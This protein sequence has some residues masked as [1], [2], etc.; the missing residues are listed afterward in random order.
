[1]RPAGR[2]SSCRNFATPRRRSDFASQNASRAASALHGARLQL[3]TTSPDGPAQGALIEGF[4]NKVPKV[5]VGSVDTLLQVVRAFGARAL[6]AQVILKA[7]P[8]IFESKDAKARE[9]AKLIVVGAPAAAAAVRW[10]ICAP[11]VGDRAKAALLR[12]SAAHCVECCGKHAVHGWSSVAPAGPP[13][14]EL[15]R[16]MG[17][18]LIKSCLYDKLRDAQKEELDKLIADAPPGRPQVRGAGQH[19]CCMSA[20]TGVWKPVAGFLLR[21]GRS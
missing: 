11:R 1:M 12:P 2:H 9:L 3:L 20:A 21:S 5:V 4:G 7:L 6:P 18:E 14:V 13:Q 10:F 15:A 16:W 8:P 17:P 19:G